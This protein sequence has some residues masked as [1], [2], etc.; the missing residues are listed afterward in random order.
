M[1]TITGI[2]MVGKGSETFLKACL[3]NHLMY[4]DE[5]IFQLDDLEHVPEV[6]EEYQ[7]KHPDKI[8]I[9]GFKCQAEEHEYGRTW[10][11]EA[12]ARNN[13]RFKATKEW[14][15]QI[16]VD[17]LYH[18]FFLDGLGK[19][20]GEAKGD[21]FYFAKLNFWTSKD[22]LRIDHSW[23]PDVGG[24][25][26]FRNRP[27]LK[28]FGSEHPTVWDGSRMC[29]MS[30]ANMAFYPIYHYKRIFPIDMKKEGNFKTLNLD[31]LRVIRNI[32]IHP[33]ASK[34]I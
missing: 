21:Y 9:I 6:L 11:D 2:T 20:L 33:E 12:V 24:P 10:Q 26:L 15:L 13:L 18:P 30:M 29:V 31:R 28:Y 14:I 22:I 27:E 25:K 17:E 23:Y 8:R 34:F 19:D 4:L 7:W 3:E 32:F 16:D 1:S 5:W